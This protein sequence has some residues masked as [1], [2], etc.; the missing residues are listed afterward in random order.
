VREQPPYLQDLT[1]CDFFLFPKLKG[2]MKGTRLPDIEA[3]KMAVTKELLVTPDRSFQ[4]CMEVWQKRMVKCVISQGDYFEGDMVWF[5][6]CIWN[7]RLCTQSRYFSN[8]PRMSSQSHK[9]F[10]SELSKFC[11][12]I[13]WSRRVRLE[14]LRVIGLQARVN[15]ESNE[16]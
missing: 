5:S 9:P 3:I 4:E 12:V 8:T 11:R 2:V 13:T 16:V 7:N 14:L 10:E 1:P 15:V 6:S